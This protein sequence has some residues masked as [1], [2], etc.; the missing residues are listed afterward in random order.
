V[1]TGN[2]NACA[3]MYCKVCKSATALYGLYLSVIKSE[4]VTK[5]LI[6]PIIRFV[7]CIALHVTIDR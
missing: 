5:L 1:E 2:P 3:T 4:C 7:E 6:N